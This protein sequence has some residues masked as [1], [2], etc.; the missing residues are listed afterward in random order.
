MHGNLNHPRLELQFIKKP[1]L[2]MIKSLTLEITICHWPNGGFSRVRIGVL[3]SHGSPRGDRTVTMYM[4]K[5]SKPSFKSRGEATFLEYS[6]TLCHVLFPRGYSCGNKWQDDYV[7]IISFNYCWLQDFVLWS[8]WFQ[9]FQMIRR[10]YKYTAITKLTIF[11]PLRF[12][13][14]PFRVFHFFSNQEFGLF[15]PKLFR[16]FEE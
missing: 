12:D 7:I 11:F 9:R 3:S 13:F 15:G 6:E 5:Y 10:D 14:C 2:W 16:H 4:K 1:N 8:R